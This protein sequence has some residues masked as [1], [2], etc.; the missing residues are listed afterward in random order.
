MGALFTIGHAAI[1]V[2]ALAALVLIACLTVALSSVY[3]DRYVERHSGRRPLLPESVEMR[4]RRERVELIARIRVYEI[5]VRCG[6]RRWERVEA[7][8]TLA[9][10]RAA[11]LHDRVADLDAARLHKMIAR[12]PRRYPPGTSI[13][14][15]RLTERLLAAGKV[16]PS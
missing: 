6:A 11:R 14:M 13:E 10:D 12:R 16:L 5:D 9:L 4:R 7:E 1:G 2:A 3:G 15:V 8:A